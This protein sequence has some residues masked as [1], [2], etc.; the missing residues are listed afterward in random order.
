MALDDRG[1]VRIPPCEL[2][3]A[4]GERLGGQL[5]RHVNLTIQPTGV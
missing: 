4:L 2:G 1:K 5:E 3:D